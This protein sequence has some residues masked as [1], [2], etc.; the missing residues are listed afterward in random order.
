MSDISGV[1]M[2]FENLALRST[3][4]RASRQAARV[5]LRTARATQLDVT[6]LASENE[7]DFLT[8]FQPWRT[9]MKNVLKGAAFGAIQAVA[10]M[11]FWSVLATVLIVYVAKGF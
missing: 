9:D 5:V 10:V 4:S 8:A 1:P 6:L 11:G 3:P 7:P 2:L